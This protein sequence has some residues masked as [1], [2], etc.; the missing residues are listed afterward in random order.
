MK[1]LP[2]WGLALALLATASAAEPP[3]DDAAELPSADDIYAAGK[4]L[5]DELAPPEIKE[6]FEFPDKARWDDVMR[7]LQA[8]LE[9]SDPQ[10][11]LPFEPE[12]RAAL[13]ALRNV[14]GGDDY[15]DWLAERLD[16]IEAAKELPARP[17]APVAGKPATQFIP[18]YELWV[19]R[20]QKRA[21]PAGAA[22]LVPRLRPVFATGGV[23]GDL[24]WLAEVE[25]GFN[26]SA[27]SPV[28][29][30]GLF[31]LMPATAKELGL[32]TLLPDERTDPE[33]SSK[34]AADYL[35]KLHAR[36]GDWPLAIA[37]YNAGGGRVSRALAK[38]KAKS[39]AEIASTLSVET[40][41]YV[42][43]VLATLQVRAGTSIAGPGPKGGTR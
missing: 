38:Q 26:P 18:N 3:A 34:A 29:A 20:T 36:F 40:Q 5:F 13:A 33:K 17:P 10:A 2:R 16:Y 41:M 4:N 14:P 39:F 28:G 22:A 9:G 11:L 19:R 42:P 31:Q 43:K 25:S 37:A 12:V 23:P 1:T 7:R 30:R 32:S 27:R 24:V 6:Q 35:H 8:A 21:Q 15:A